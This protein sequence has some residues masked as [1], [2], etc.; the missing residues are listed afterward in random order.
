MPV[1]EGGRGGLR[2]T[3]RIL[4]I[5]LLVLDNCFMEAS[6]RAPFVLLWEGGRVDPL[7]GFEGWGKFTVW[8]FIFLEGG[9]DQPFCYW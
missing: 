1:E 5:L 6:S 9:G 7:Q 8:V 2:F 3:V 4:T